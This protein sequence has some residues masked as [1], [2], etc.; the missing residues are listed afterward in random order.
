M[1]NIILAYIKFSVV[2]AWNIFKKLLSWKIKL[3]Q[4]NKNLFKIQH[5]FYNST[6]GWLVT[7]KMIKS[8][9]LKT[10]WTLTLGLTKQNTFFEDSY[11]RRIFSVQINCIPSNNLRWKEKK[12]KHKKH[13]NV[14]DNV[15][16]PSMIWWH[17]KKISRWIALGNPQKWHDFLKRKPLLSDFKSNF[18]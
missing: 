3:E 11:A 10:I 9:F 1:S 13:G 18:L 7:E 6:K 5:L 14:S 8:I 16:K 15:L 12:R 4:G 17:N 2:Y